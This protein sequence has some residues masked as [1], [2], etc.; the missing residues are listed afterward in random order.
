MPTAF[1]DS[2]AWPASASGGWSP[3]L[4]SYFTVL[5]GRSSS[6]RII[7]HRGSPPAVALCWKVRRIFC[8][9]AARILAP[10]GLDCCA[11]LLVH[12]SRS[13]APQDDLAVGNANDDLAED[14]PS[15]RPTSDEV[16]RRSLE[17]RRVEHQHLPIVD[18]EDLNIW[19]YAKFFDAEGAV[20]LFVCAAVMLMMRLV[21]R[22]VGLGPRPWAGAAGSQAGSDDAYQ[23]AFVLW[24]K[25][26]GALASSSSHRHGC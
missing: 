3:S 25:L 21:H 5:C 13:R 1:C 9:N 14:A 7:H 26:F 23:V 11:Q 20:V 19:P 24:I 18:D 6:T 8:G 2:E 10:V 4:G 16:T 17:Q 12:S 15:P 22:E